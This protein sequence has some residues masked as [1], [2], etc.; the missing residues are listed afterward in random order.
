MNPLSTLRAVGAFVKL[1]TDLGRLNEVFSLADG[2]AD[3]VNLGAVR[4]HVARDGVGAAALRERSRVRVDIASLRAL[5]PGT[6]GRAFAEHMIANDLDPAA[7]PT[8]PD[9]DELAYIRAHLYE[10]HDLWHVVTG[11]GTDVPGELGLQAF[12]SAQLPGKLPTAILA[13][14]FVNTLVKHF[15]ERDARLQQIVRGFVLGRRARQ[16]FGVR[17]DELW[18]TPLVEVRRLLD[19]DLAALDT[20]LPDAPLRAAA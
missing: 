18:S 7:I 1:A 13:A 14:A 11:F 16:L 4:D 9:G 20:L 10:T 17:W 5:P 6:L 8:L 15:E 12:Y 3:P 2:L 19:V